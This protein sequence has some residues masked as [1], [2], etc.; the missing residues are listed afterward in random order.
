M[1]NLP[2]LYFWL[3]SN[4]CSY[5]N[6]NQF[7]KLF[8]F[9]K[10]RQ[11]LHIS[12]RGSSCSSRSKCRPRRAVRSAGPALPPDRS[13]RSPWGHIMLIKGTKKVEKSY[14]LHWI[15][16]IGASLTS[17]ERLWNEFVV[18]GQVSSTVDARIRPVTTLG[19]VSLERFHHPA[20]RRAV[21]AHRMVDSYTSSK[22][23]MSFC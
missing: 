17:L 19:Q 1:M 16:E 2:S 7:K 22:V 15:E 8:Q 14:K 13:P 12:S 3:D 23:I 11:N 5:V 10:L 20:L 9:G 21:R 6:L 18:I 4:A